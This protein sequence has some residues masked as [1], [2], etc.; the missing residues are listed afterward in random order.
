MN[1]ICL[2]Y[3]RYKYLIKEADVLLFRTTKFPNFGWWIGKYTKSP[4]SHAALASWYDADVMC[5][6][7]REFA[8]SRVYPL[9]EYLK[10]GS[11]IDVFRACTKI[12]FPVV[13]DQQKPFEDF[14]TINM[15]DGVRHDITNIAKKLMGLKYSKWVIWQLA[16]TFMPFIRLGHKINTKNG[17]I[18]NTKFVCSTLVSYSYRLNYADPVPF[19]SDAYTTPGDLARSLLFQKIFQ[20]I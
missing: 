2:E 16:K 15:D 6:E 1:D 5:L 11:K 14:H 8:G 17:D 20:I 3:D 10:E 12:T 19:L 7:F 9:T 18:D 4:Y 13:N